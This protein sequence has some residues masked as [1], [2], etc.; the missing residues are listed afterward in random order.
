ML[1]LDYA[2]GFV[3]GEG[4][5]TIIKGTKI[6][7]GIKRYEYRPCVVVVNSNEQVINEFLN[8]GGKVYKKKRYS[9]YKQSWHW[10]IHDKKAVDFCKLIL[11]KL[12]V[13][14][15]QAQ[16]LTELQKW[17]IRCGKRSQDTLNNQIKFYELMK[18]TNNWHSRYKM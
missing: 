1:N 15:S 13:K 8:F 16:I 5:I 7:N 2:A 4:C 3:D 17:K 18:Q 12:I 14:K 10:M 11:N 9:N 6:I